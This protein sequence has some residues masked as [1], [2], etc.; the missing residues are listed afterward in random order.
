MVLIPAQVQRGTFDTTSVPVIIDGDTSPTPTPVMSLIGALDVGARVMVLF[1]P[2]HG[3]YIIGIITEAGWTA[4]PFNPGEWE[5]Y[6]AAS[7][8]CEYRRD[9][10]WVTLRGVAKRSGGGVSMVVGTLPTGF[11]PTGGRENFAVDSDTQEH[12]A[13]VV[14]PSG[15]IEIEL[16]PS[17]SDVYVSLSGVRF[18]VG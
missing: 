15:D 6:G 18:W 2:P 8:V 10:N 5:N 13:V 7:Q 14:D 17:A 4:L 3:A 12:S 1:W 9:G 16:G 11:I